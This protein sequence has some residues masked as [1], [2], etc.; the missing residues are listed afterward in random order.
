MCF[1]VAWE[2]HI[3]AAVVKNSQQTDRTSQ[4]SFYNFI[5]S[6]RNDA[7]IPITLLD[8]RTV[9]NPASNLIGS[10]LKPDALG[11]RLSR[12]FWTGQFIDCPGEDSVNYRAHVLIVRIL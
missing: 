6:C 7:F 2:E 1:D 3:M 11:Y 10:L 4:A 12:L 9:T 8:A 5:D